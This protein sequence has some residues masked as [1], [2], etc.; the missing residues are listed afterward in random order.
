[1]KVAHTHSS[2]FKIGRQ[3]VHQRT[4]IL[5]RNL[6]FL[7]GAVDV[8]SEIAWRAIKPAPYSP[9]DETGEWIW[10]LERYYCWVGPL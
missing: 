5:S 3:V 7:F 9:G 1:M 4:N 2:M 6:V 8:Y 10:K